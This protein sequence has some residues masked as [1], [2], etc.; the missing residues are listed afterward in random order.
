[1]ALYL[2]SDVDF[3]SNCV[4]MLDNYT[5][6][7][8]SE[9][10]DNNSFDGSYTDYALDNHYIKYYGV[11]DTSNYPSSSSCYPSSELTHN[12]I[13]RTDFIDIFVIGTGLFLLTFLVF[14]KLLT[15]LFRGWF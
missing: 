9:S 11:E 3:D 2:P 5:A 4:I 13:E 6:R 7:V 12:V 10:P 8:Y 1:M 14:Y 15:Y